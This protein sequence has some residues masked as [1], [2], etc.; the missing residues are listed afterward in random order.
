M[1]QYSES[2]FSLMGHTRPHLDFF[3]IKDYSHL[4]SMASNVPIHIY[5]KL[6]QRCFTE[7]QKKA[8]EPRKN[9]ASTPKLA[10]EVKK[11]KLPAGKECRQ[12]PDYRG[13][14]H[15]SLAGPV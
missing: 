3:S 13:R 7:W 4:A 6:S 14:A 2:L 15:P 8:K 11:K 1:I 12:E 9:Q 5:R 10:C